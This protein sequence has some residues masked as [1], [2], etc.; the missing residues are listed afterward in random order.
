MATLTNDGVVFVGGAQ[1]ASEMVNT[2]QA[3]CESCDLLLCGIRKVCPGWGWNKEESGYEGQF[4]IHYI[5]GMPLS[6]LLCL[7]KKIPVEDMGDVI[8]QY[9]VDF[10]TL[11]GQ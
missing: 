1:L 7:L 9:Y 4:A 6:L 3:G 11:E 2:A 8:A 5:P 10:Y